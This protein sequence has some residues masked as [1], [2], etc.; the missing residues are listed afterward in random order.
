MDEGIRCD[1]ESSV[2]TCRFHDLEQ[3]CNSTWPH[4]QQ[5]VT[6]ILNS[7]VRFTWDHVNK[8]PN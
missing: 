2:L 1:F 8:F 7:T 3:M 5:Y 4:L 6:S